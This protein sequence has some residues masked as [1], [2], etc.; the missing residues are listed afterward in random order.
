MKVSAGI[1]IVK[2]FDNH[3]KFL[4]LR[5]GNFYEPPKG[6]VELKESKFDAAVRETCEETTLKPEDLNFE[7]GFV[8]K[9]TD[10]Y[11][12]GKKY[13]K[14]FLAK[15]NV[16]NIQPRVN[17]ELGKAEHQESMWLTYQEAIKLA[18]D[19]IKKILEWANSIVT[20]DV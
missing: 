15:V 4:I 1:V 14:Y 20:K 12:K 3:Y 17:K 5:N 9:D 10:K 13:V 18:N 8:N 7:W 16:D 2:L 19:R 6:R 11:M